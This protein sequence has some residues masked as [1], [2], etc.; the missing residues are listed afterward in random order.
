MT[1]MTHGPMEAFGL[2][3]ARRWIM[4]FILLLLLLALIQH[5]N[6]SGT[7]IT[8]ITRVLTAL[9]GAALLRQSWRRKQRQCKHR[10]EYVLQLHGG[11][12]KPCV[13][14]LV[15]TSRVLLLRQQVS[16]QPVTPSKSFGCFFWKAWRGVPLRHRMEP[17]DAKSA[18]AL[19]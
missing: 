11:L 15:Q 10:Q 12:L 16:F 8:D 2:A 6:L 14:N 7:L 17:Q 18:C 4:I 13:R 19:Q 9:V 1:Q 5:M 3:G